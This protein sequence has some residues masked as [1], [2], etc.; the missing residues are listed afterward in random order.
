MTLV[1]VVFAVAL[2]AM[3]FGTILKGLIQ[4][5]LR[6]SWISF[7]AAA[8]RIAEQRIEQTQNARWEPATPIDELTA[9][10]FPTAT[11]VLD[12]NP[13]GGT[14]VLATSVVQITTVTNGTIVCKV[15]QSQVTWSFFNRGPFTNSVVTIRSPDQ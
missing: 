15:L 6:A 2:F 10:N 14:T 12:T 1:E 9:S 13:G 3:V 7:D 5:N 11:Y 8:S 4:V